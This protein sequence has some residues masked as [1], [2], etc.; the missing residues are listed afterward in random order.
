VTRVVLL[1]ENMPREVGI[2]L[3]AAGYDVL[4]VASAARGADDRGVLA[5][6][7]QAARVLLTFDADF[8]DLIFQRGEAPPPAVLYFRIHPIVAAEVLRLALAALAQPNDGCFVVAAREGLRSRRFDAV[9]DE[10][11][12]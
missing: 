5:L 3:S 4:T 2:G 12:N 8:G 9:A 10:G 11:A 6:A 7:R 1:D